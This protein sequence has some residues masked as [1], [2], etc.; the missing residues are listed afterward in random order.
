MKLRTWWGLSP[1]G[2]SSPLSDTSTQRPA[3]PLSG[4]LSRSDGVLSIVGV[5]CRR[6]S[7]CGRAVHPVAPS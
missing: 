2:G 6:F 1:R 7:A 5:V 3:G 4:L